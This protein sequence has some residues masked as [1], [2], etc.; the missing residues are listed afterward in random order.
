MSINNN[1]AMIRVKAAQV[2]DAVVNKGRSLDRAIEKA[3]LDDDNSQKS[4]F[5][6][7]CFGT[8][9]FYWEL[10]LQLGQYVSRPIRRKDNIIETLLIIGLFQ[11]KKTRI[12]PH[13]IVVQTVEAVRFLKKPNLTA[14]VNAVL[15]SVIRSKSKEFIN[16]NEEALFNHP[17]WLIKMLKNSWPRNWQEIIENNNK[18]APMWLRVNQK[19]IT[20]KDYLK[21]IAHSL[22]L[23][24][25]EVGYIGDLGQSICLKN[26]I[27]IK[28]L[29]D[30]YNGHVSVQDGGAQIAAECLLSGNGGRILDACA[31]PGG[32]TGQLIEKINDDS[33]VTAVDIDLDRAE[34]IR[35]NLSRL[36]L[37]ANI[38]TADVANTKSWWDSKLFDLILIDAPCSATGV[39]RRHPDIKH[40]KREKD[41]DVLNKIQVNIVNSLWALLKPGGKLLYVTCS[42]LIEENDSVISEL[43]K[44]H[45]D[46]LVNNLLL[47]NNIHDVM[48]KTN[49]GYQLLP[50]T[51]EMDGFYFSYLE[52]A[53][54]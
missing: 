19:K 37:K 5:K 7:I 52:K 54:L 22:N 46:V 31:A 48:H 28:L 13:A 16:A 20:S 39:I 2:V 49:H 45:P 42:V 38:I 33:E 24:I 1:G 44:M 50:G 47:N 12:P 10:K 53:I 29:P 17:A 3:N 32:K 4:L 30:F 11:I 43:R 27:S 23:S 26:P 15:R 8:I 6:A 51:K 21:K 18:Q 25:D 14:F 41:I 36:E 9:R 34:I 35:E 40:L